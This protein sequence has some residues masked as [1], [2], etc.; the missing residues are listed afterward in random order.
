MAV[1][2]K[3][4]FWI[5]FAGLV[6][7]GLLLGVV[8]RAMAQPIYV[9]TGLDV[10]G[11]VNTGAVGIYAAEAITPSWTCLARSLRVQEPGE[12]TMPARSL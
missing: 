8:G 12:S 4:T 9:Y 3:R 6:S 10:P 7:L 5:S 11:A 2:P 1:L